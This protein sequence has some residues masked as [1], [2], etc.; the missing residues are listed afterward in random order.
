MQSL[1]IREILTLLNQ[2]YI[3]HLAFIFDD[4]PYT[5]PITYYFNQKDA[6]LAYSRDGLKV[7]AMRKNRNVALQAEHIENVEK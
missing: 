1:Q 2:K 6:V 4:K 5:V 3:G 7:Q